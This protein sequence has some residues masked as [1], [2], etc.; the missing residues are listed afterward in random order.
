MTGEINLSLAHDTFIHIPHRY[1]QVLNKEW[2]FLLQ[3]VA[4]TLKELIFEHRVS[5]RVSD[6]AGDGSP[7]P[8]SKRS[9]NRS[10]GYHL[11]YAAVSTEPNRGDELLCRPVL[12]L[13]SEESN[14]FSPAEAAFVQ[15]N[16]SQGSANSDRHR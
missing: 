6:I 7:H 16:P 8:E 12:R 15:G 11:N 4:G 2:G 9:S 13:S 10:S 1:E 5:M 14:S 3:A